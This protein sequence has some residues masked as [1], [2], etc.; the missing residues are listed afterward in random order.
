MNVREWLLSGDKAVAALVRR[1]L[2]NEMVPHDNTGLI[3][4]HLQ[5]FDPVTARFGGGVYGPKWV[6]TH[7]TMVEL[8]A[9]E[10]DPNTRE[11]QAGLKTLMTHLWPGRL[12]RGVYHIDLCIPGMVLEMLAYAKV[13]DNII[14]EIIDYLL[15][16]QMPDGGW[17]CRIEG[18]KKPRVS[19]VHTTIN[20][21]EGLVR[22]AQGAH[23]HRIDEVNHAINRGIESLLTRNLIYKKGTKAPIHHFM[24]RAHYPPRWKYD[25]LRG[26]VLLANHNHPNDP[27]MHDAL[28]R[29]RAQMIKGRFLRGK[30]IPGVIA[31]TLEEG[32]FGRF[33]TL[34]A[35]RVLKRYDE[36][37]FHQALTTHAD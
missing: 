9:L 29:L 11:Y 22:I 12:P 18:E 33:N 32:R 2:L 10:V 37:A 27:R 4:K 20:V 3:E 7:Y 28:E 17:N 35:L 15:D 23:T 6:S 16:F 5:R 30:T 13:D 21:L 19:S 31:F 24:T 34:R 1:H 26:L 25:Y 36:T 14:E 8:T